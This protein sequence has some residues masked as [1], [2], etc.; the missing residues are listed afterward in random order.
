MLPQVLPD[1]ECARHALA[2]RRQVEDVDARVALLH[3]G[4]L[5]H[6][7]VERGDPVVVAGQQRNLGTRDAQPCERRRAGGFGQSLEPQIPESRV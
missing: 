4:G 3:V 6:V 1:I 2:L 7:A 5:G